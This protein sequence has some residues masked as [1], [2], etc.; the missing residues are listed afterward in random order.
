CTPHATTP[1]LA[2]KE[3][4]T[5]GRHHR[6]RGCT[7]PVLPR[8]A[9]RVAQGAEA[10]RAGR[11]AR[12]ARDR[13]GLEVRR[14]VLVEALGS[15]AAR[16]ERDR[17]RLP[18]RD[19]EGVIGMVQTARDATNEAEAGPDAIRELIDQALAERNAADGFNRKNK[20]T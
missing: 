2:P 7:R 15:R 14:P 20:V 10:C 3:V 13:P 11:P 4:P 9:R 12:A 17:R 19:Q 1:T 16:F 5:D 18:L 6:H 8:A